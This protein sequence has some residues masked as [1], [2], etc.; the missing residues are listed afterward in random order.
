[1]TDR[2]QSNTSCLCRPGTYDNGMQY[3]CL[4]CHVQCVTCDGGTNSSC[5]GCDASMKRVI[6]SATTPNFCNCMTHYYD[7]GPAACSTC[8]SQC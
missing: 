2:Y 7:E 5:L 6:A 3:S 1:M 8:F 4:P